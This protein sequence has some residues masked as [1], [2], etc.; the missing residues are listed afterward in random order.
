MDVLWMFCLCVVFFFIGVYFH[1]L[2]KKK[3]ITEKQ[4]IFRLSDGRVINNENSRINIFKFDQIDF[5]LQDFN[6]NTITV[7]K[8]Q[9]ISSLGLFSCFFDIKVK[10]F[11][12]FKCE[13]PLLKEIKQELLKRLYKPIYIPII[14]IF[15]C[16]LII[17]SRIQKIMTSH[18][19]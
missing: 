16:F 11:A 9:E 17:S 5:S 18:Y 8:I 14:T 19:F 2:R 10:K 3:D 12:S 4:K 7:P 6:S 13:Q 1:I 15:C